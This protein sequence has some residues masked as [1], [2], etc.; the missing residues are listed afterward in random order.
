MM[1]GGLGDPREGEGV[2][3]PAFGGGRQ[4]QFT[5]SRQ[6]PGCDRLVSTLLDEVCMVVHRKLWVLERSF[7][8][9]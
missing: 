2:Q 6:P 5:M 9:H 1:Q 7:Q 8:N 3:Y 4:N